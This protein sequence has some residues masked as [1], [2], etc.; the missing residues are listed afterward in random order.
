MAGGDEIS[1]DF[2]YQQYFW[3]IFMYIS[4]WLGGLVYIALIL[5]TTS[6]RPLI[7]HWESGSAAWQIYVYIYKSH[8]YTVRTKN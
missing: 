2:C 7:H 6:R 3:N 1:M 5:Q 8:Q 4:Q